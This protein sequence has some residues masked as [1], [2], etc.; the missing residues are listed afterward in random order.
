MS[1][2]MYAP[3]LGSG[4]P[5]MLAALLGLMFPAMNDA[6][7]Q[8]SE[9]SGKE[10]VETVC[11]ACHRTGD[12]GAP[13][14]G[15]EKAWARLA[16][17]GL[18]GLSES[19]LK[20]I[21]NMPA[22]GGKP[23]LSDVEIERAITYM[24]NQSGGNWIEPMGGLTPAVERRGEQIVAMQCAACHRSGEGGAP[25]IGN[26]DDWIPRLKHGLDVLVRSAIHGHGPMPARGGLPD[27]TD[28]EIRGAIAYMFDPGRVTAK[29]RP[30]PLPTGPAPFHR[31]VGGVEV[32]LGI[33]SADAIRR[34]Y[35]KGSPEAGMHGGIPRGRGYY[36]LNV[37][38]F[39]AQTK[40]PITD[41]HVEASVREPTSA[42]SKKLELV[43]LH[44]TTSYGQYFSMPSKNPY[45][46]EVRIRR[47]GTP[48]AIESAF[49]YRHR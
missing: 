48:R 11:A 25:R 47:P 27:L 16:S 28:S 34:Q 8:R 35:P 36:H 18:T 39:D 33:V 1:D 45:T 2:N 19:A 5:L 29:A 43:T 42:D 32:F 44:N 9:Q 23:T 38:L 20:G 12:K 21:R 6:S 37:S 46:I 41:A 22:H 40:A 49:E 10:V 7:A 31:T 17:R 4:A 13:R 14:I 3:R 24:V 30:A 15:D 26:R